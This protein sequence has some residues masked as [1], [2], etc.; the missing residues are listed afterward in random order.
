MNVLAPTLHDARAPLNMVSL[1]AYLHHVL[2]ENTLAA[3][4]GADD[5][6]SPI[7]K[8]D[9][10]SGND[11]VAKET[12]EPCSV[13]GDSFAGTVFCCS[14]TQTSTPGGCAYGFW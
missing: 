11:S 13:A 12:D 10:W 7:D 3:D 2:L 9:D 4:G 1:I 8:T 14:A 6:G 5:E